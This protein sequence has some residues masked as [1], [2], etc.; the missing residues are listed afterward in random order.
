MEERG[1]FEEHMDGDG[2]TLA[3]HKSSS[4]GS[5]VSFRGNRGATVSQHTHGNSHEY[6]HLQTPGPVTHESEGQSNVKAPGFRCAE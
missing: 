6:Q 1:C 3:A 2:C 4:L 5:S